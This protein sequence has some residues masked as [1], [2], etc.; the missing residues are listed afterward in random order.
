M[1]AFL[2]LLMEEMK[3][4][5]QGV[6]A[7]D[8]YLKCRF[9]LRAAYIWPIHDYLAY[10]KIASWCVHGRLNYPI[11][12]DVTDAFRPQHGKKVSFFDCH[13]R[14]F[15]SNQPFRNDTRS[16][17]KGKTIRKWPPK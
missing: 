9:N 13:Q 10:E 3:E 11:Y 5:G 4:L 14:F 17:L 15:P 16:F 12:M 1:N 6:N 8:S 7:Y 2:H